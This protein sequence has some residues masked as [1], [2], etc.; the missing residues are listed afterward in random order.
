[1]D[2]SRRILRRRYARD[3]YVV[4]SLRSPVSAIR[5]GAQLLASENVRLKMV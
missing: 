5:T 1:M 2:T 3:V 4:L